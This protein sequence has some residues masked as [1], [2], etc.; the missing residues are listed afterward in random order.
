[1]VGAM[2][3]NERSL[4]IVH[5][6]TYDIAGGA[7][8]VAWR[9]AEAQ[10][11]AGCDSRMVVGIKNSDSEHSSA[12]PIECDPARQP[13]CKEHGQLFYDCQGSHKLTANPAVKSAD[14][15]HLHN[16]H[17]GYFN[18]FSL[19]VLSHL[20]PLVWTLHDMQ[21]I[22]GYCAHSFD[23]E[24]WQTGCGLCPDLTIFPKLQVDT[25]AQLWND[26]KLIYDNSHLFL[27]APS[28]WLKS[29]IEKSILR[30][31]PVELIYNCCDTNVFRPYDKK[32]AKRKLGIPE[33]TLVIG[34]VARDGPL[35]NRWKGGQYTQ[36]AL[37]ALRNK[38]PDYIFLNVG[39]DFK[40][41]D[42]GIISTGQI[43]DENEL[44]HIYTALD[45]Y[46]Y[47][48]LADNCPLV[49]IETLSCGVPI[50]TFNTG[51]VP[52]LVRDGVDG[53]VSAYKDL[54]GVVQGLER[55]SANP[56]LRA[57]F[58]YN[59]RQRAISKFDHKIIVEQY[60]KF[61]HRCIEEHKTRA[62]NI[63]LFPLEKVPK[64]VLTRPFME[65]ENSKKLLMYNIQ[66]KIPFLADKFHNFTYS[67][68]SH[69]DFFKGYDLDLYK[70]PIDPETCDLKRYQDLLVFTFI[71]HHIP[72]GSRILDVGGGANSR[73]L[74]YFKDD[75]ECWNV[76]KLE[77]VG[78]RGRTTELS[79]IN[80]AYHRLIHD[81][82]GNFNKDLPDNY[83]DF[84]FS[85]SALEHT[86]SEDKEFLE[87]IRDDINRVL[88]PGGYSLHC[89]DVVIKKDSVWTNKLMPFLFQDL[90]TINTFVPLE[91]L[92]ED[93]D[94][95]ILTE[96][97]YR[98]RWQKI[99][100]QTYQDFGLPLSYNILWQKALCPVISRANSKV[101]DE[102]ES[103]E[104]SLAFRHNE[105][106]IKPKDRC[107]LHLK[108]THQD[109]LN[110]QVQQKKL[111]EESE[112]YLS[113]VVTARNDNHGDS[114]LKRMQ[115]FLN[116]LFSQS[117]NYTLDTE[118]VLVEWNPPQDKP[119]LAEVL[120]WPKSHQ[121]CTVR[122]IKVPSKVHNRFKYAHTL[123]LYQMIAKNVGV[124]RA[125]GEYIL[126]TNID[127]LFSN[128]LFR[129]LA[130]RKLEKGKLYRTDRYDVR[131][132]IPLEA[133]LEEQLAF[134]KENVI[135]VNKPDG[136][137][138]LITGS[139]YKTDTFS[140][141]NA[142][143]DFQL[144]HRDHW[145]AL[146]GY[147]EFD[148]YPLRI[149]SIL[150]F[151]SHFS[152]IE[153]MHLTNPMKIYHIDHRSGGSP[154]AHKNRLKN[155]DM[156]EFTGEE[157]KI[158]VDKMK[159]EKK[160]I[161]FND[162]NFG[163]ALED[164]EDKTVVPSGPYASN[165]SDFEITEIEK[166]ALVIVIDIHE[167]M[168]SDNAYIVP[169]WERY[170][171]ENMS[172]LCS[173]L[174][175]C[176]TNDIKIQEALYYGKRNRRL[177]HIRF[178][179]TLEDQLDYSS[180]S[181]IYFCGISLDQCVVNRP[182]GYFKLQHKNKALIKNCSFQGYKYTAPIDYGIA[183][184]S[185]KE[186]GTFVNM[187][188]LTNRVNDFLKANN[189]RHVNWAG[190]KRA[191]K[192]VTKSGN[193]CFNPKP[194]LS[195][196]VTSRNDDHGGNGLHR[197]QVFAKG[198]AEQCKRFNLNAELI[199]VEWN[200]PADRK[201]LYEILQWPDDLG[202]LTVRF[203]EVPP[204]IHE[205]IS[206]SDK[207]P[208]FQWI[209]KNVGIRRTRGNFVLS[210]NIDILFSDELI[211]F[212]ASYQLDENCFYRIDRHDVT[213][214][215][216][217]NI[218]IQKQLDFC[219][220]NLIRVQGLYGTK[221]ISQMPSDHFIYSDNDTKPHTNACGD[222]TLMA[223]NK[224]QLFRGYPELPRGDMFIDGLI[225]HMAYVS[226]LHQV[227][228]PEP[229]RIYHIEH[230][231]GWAVKRK[232]PVRTTLSLDYNK[233]YLPWCQRMIDQAKP[234]T[235]NDEHWGYAQTEFKEHV[236][237]GRWKGQMTDKN[238]TLQDNNRKLFQEW[239]DTLAL[240]QNRLYYRDQTPESLNMLVELVHSYKPT[241]IVELGTLSGFSLRAWLSAQSEAEV[242]AIDLSFKPL[243]RSQ[244][245][246]PVELSGVRLLEQDIL[247][248]DF[249]QLWSEEDRVLLYIDA[250]DQLNT[251]IMTHILDNALPLLPQGS[252]VTVDDLWYCPEVLTNDS[253]SKFFEEVTINEI[254]PLQCFEGY[255]APYWKGG[256]F[257]GFRE[258]VP[259]VEWINC[260]NVELILNPG[261]KTVTFERPLLRKSAGESFDI[262]GFGRSTGS[263]RYNPVKIFSDFGIK[264]ATELQG[265]GALCEAGA[266]FYASGRIKEAEDCF[267]QAIFLDP[268]IN[269]AFYA[270]AVCFAR[271][272][273]FE[274]ATEKLRMEMNSKFPHPRA[275]KLYEDIKQ[276]IRKKHK[277]IST[278]QKA[279]SSRNI[280]IFAIP[281]QFVG[282]IGLIQS[283][284]IKSWTLLEPRPE[285]ILF[286]DD[287]GVAEVAEKFGLR[288]IPDVKQ[289]VSGVPLV[290]DL[291]EKAQDMA[292]NDIMA[293][294]NCD[295][296]LLS[297][298]TPAVRR[299]SK[300]FN[301]FLMIEQR[302]DTD[303]PRPIDF[304]DADWEQKLR[305]FVRQNASLH[306]VTGVDC[307]V[308]TK[309]LWS[310]IPPFGIGR[311]MWDIWLVRKALQDNKDIIDATET[312]MIVHQNHPYISFPGR[313]A[314]ELANHQLG[315][316]QFSSGFVSDAGW[317]LTPTGLIKKGFQ[318][319]ND[320]EVEAIQLCQKAV[321]KLRQNEPSEAL[322]ILD[323]A[324]HKSQAE[325]LAIAG[326]QT[327][328]AV[329]LLKS[330][331]MDE[332]VSA[333]EAELSLQPGNKDGQRILELTNRTQKKLKKPEPTK[334]NNCTN[335]PCSQAITWEQVKQMPVIRLYAGDVPEQKEY[336]GLI[337]LSMSRNDLN[338]LR[339][340]ITHP[341]PL[342]DNSV[343]SFQAED[344][345]EHIP[346]EKLLP[347][348]NEIYRILKPDGFFR[349]SVPDYGCDVLQNR[350]I[351]DEKGQIVFDPG[352][353]GTPENPG[354][355]WFPRIDTVMQLL[356]K[357]KFHESG[358]IELL[359]YYNKDGTFV[360][361]PIDYSKGPIMRTPDFDQRVKNPYR[362]M[363]MVIDLTKDRA[364]ASQN[365]GTK[366]GYMDDKT[367]GPDKKIN[368]KSQ[369]NKCTVQPVPEGP[370]QH[371][372][373]KNADNLKLQRIGTE[374][375]GWA[376][377]L[378]LIPFGSTVVS[379]GVG[380]DISFDLGLINLKSC[381]VIGIDPT[382]KARR[383]IENNKNER[384]DFLQKA[385]YSK[386]N[387][388][389][390]IYKSNN[391]DWVSESLTPSHH[392][393]TPSQ[394]YEAETIS[395]EDILNKY[396]NVSV[397][398][399][400]IE[401]AEYEVLNS[402][403]KLD[404][405]QICIEFHHF[406]TDFTA[407]DT[408][409][410]IKH[411]QRMG[412]VLAHSTS[413]GR[414]VK[415]ATFIHQKY[416]SNRKTT[417]M[418]MGKAKS[419]AVASVMSQ[420]TIPDEKP[421]DRYLRM[422]VIGTE[423]SGCAAELEERKYRELTNYNIAGEYRR[424][425]LFHI[426][427]TGGTSLNHILLSQG[428][429]D[430][431]EVY[432]RLS[433]DKNHRIISNDKVFVGWNKKLIEQ[434]YYYYAFSHMLKHQLRL[435]EGTFTITCLRDP[436]KRVLSHY[437]MLL[438]FKVNNIVHPCMKIEGEWLGNSFNDFLTNIPTEHLLNQLYMFS[439]N[440]DVNEAFDNIVGC[441][442][443]FFTE[444]FSLGVSQL[445]SK[446]GIE[447]KPLHIRKT[448]IDVNFSRVDIDR[449][450]S[451]LEAEYVLFDK[452]KRVRL[453]LFDGYKVVST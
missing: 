284:A 179:Y 267:G 259:L 341:F 104:V 304:E 3:K 318:Q 315:D 209:A 444:Q 42:P 67:K 319:T 357:T 19:S 410:C 44:A 130:S 165:D 388:K 141:T 450:R 305:E 32:Q 331:R 250:H 237:S 196:V 7:A 21:S 299:V 401:G 348:L 370:R 308:F 64:I 145:F 93:P 268:D 385:L 199:I 120:S 411:L 402:I 285:I 23:C 347:V 289:N 155:K 110:T 233:D 191:E 322:K 99:T 107:I 248:T 147:P 229:L 213:S 452:L 377:D 247:K 391:P 252:I 345:L 256:F 170:Y 291:F 119:T 243:F 83:F 85:I 164:F 415:E 218:G 59:G 412:Y 296:I 74:N 302:W 36:T 438:E 408:E 156:R 216:P 138:N 307:F 200:P 221:K 70:R 10:R 374:Y 288:H 344:V 395:I 260:N 443:F 205:Q 149:D 419:T 150:Q 111:P 371:H 95:Y 283:N 76:D 409:K 399:M 139:I 16:L 275:K 17:K 329:C 203:I 151:T 428:G 197:M 15:L 182:L 277:P 133:S 386:S 167:K 423:Q 158:L 227:I 436:V 135:R 60:L 432:R 61:Y 353:G 89:F 323:E 185:F 146:R 390:K 105:G 219:C 210:A 293:Y 282:H 69:F 180:F 174:E 364:T 258:V 160:A 378:D 429:E 176:N 49:V 376:V 343:D 249:R 451:M 118:I 387:K 440:F 5:I 50:V 230:E 236:I 335:R 245:V 383:Y 340:D 306:A 320:P 417:E 34:A 101:N 84:V 202:F 121:Y 163:F 207:F 12:F 56:Q 274:M 328:R 224:W 297:D 431:E 52:E 144:M 280:T 198:I 122:I 441:S 171:E 361:K 166:D 255:Y 58:G 194:K 393:V 77:G 40:T 71:K 106:P 142:C 8:K 406:C 321:D 414:V 28:Q 265:A 365:Y 427:K 87:A 313:K 380:E 94:L 405:P 281:K 397:L 312:V 400:D 109:C 54:A 263:V 352:G 445:S 72:K 231:G 31:H 123:P 201:R 407:D 270:Q 181:N 65:A 24:K 45:I 206:N 175:Y 57:Q 22:T 334:L 326:L 86:P 81:Y 96:Q 128:E 433:E 82:I 214:K 301:E 148:K 124:R 336:E 184:Q 102:K 20:K 46:L 368:V 80:V 162:R 375:G 26:K 324:Q 88:K 18:P 446:L 43:N 356:T 382:E 314:E 240:T 246:L 439:K 129:F 220:N 225:V 62:T 126:A 68:K 97:A 113:I 264:D 290:N 369:V 453:N 217:E 98:A 91:K 187:M 337:G 392:T 212:L 271:E 189:I 1:M 125:R 241:K 53:F 131:E 418:N 449:L 279:E 276:Y 100:K 232:S 73:I 421:S 168:V 442:H 188:E 215:I 278:A 75:Y 195:I 9:L 186:S 272:G 242:I 116:G 355:V 177:D 269:G 437:K 193:V 4:S 108:D 41:D 373:E 342:M 354:H 261:D 226:G 286:G 316:N 422:R 228:L 78:T 325:K 143:G 2:R 30:N 310:V 244:E 14:I 372:A 253:V 358:K 183:Q 327:I 222:F 38:F 363:S 366:P 404:V 349:L 416:L 134:C 448:S 384:F 351:K 161:M 362:P 333:A 39:G 27:V 47:T 381:R 117:E 103:P 426:R 398:K 234:I 287:D 66:K 190:A 172:N 223:R 35:T 13:Y 132:T 238:A 204:E 338:H 127:I 367:K 396:K 55:L 394:F 136:T 114:L 403:S 300:R 169:D 266:Q 420:I 359:H 48:P 178:D 137:Y 413:G 273:N 63:K 51:G 157:R 6:N 303:I 154:E 159:R 332:A 346:H 294:V 254:D 447:L 434:G 257:V 112:K 389:I 292:T 92:E 339:H 208:L 251:S 192:T 90:E 295:I 11:I 350:S 29:K 153:E 311:T 262:E 424:I 330:G 317:K 115:I 152:G 235:N 211:K 425:Y 298:F 79:K 173:L 33:N 379:A 430:R 25:T 435:P 360:A 239:I 309:Y 37:T 140:Y